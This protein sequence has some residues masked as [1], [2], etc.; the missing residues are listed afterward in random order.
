MRTACYTFVALSAMSANLCQALRLSSSRGI[1]FPFSPKFG[2]NDVDWARYHANNVNSSIDVRHS[3]IYKAHMDGHN[4]IPAHIAGTEQYGTML[5]GTD[6]YAPHGKCTEPAASLNKRIVFENKVD[7]T[8]VV[9]FYREEIT[10]RE[11][12]LDLALNVYKTGFGTSQ[13]IILLTAGFHYEL[14]N[15]MTIYEAILKGYYFVHH[16]EV[17]NSA[18]LAKLKKE[19]EQKNGGA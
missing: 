6:P 14:E 15:D 2:Q 10:F 5:I 3:R 4:G 9:R 13:D 7:G 19:Y 8:S 1:Q 11:I 18:T 17:H 16:L 12:K